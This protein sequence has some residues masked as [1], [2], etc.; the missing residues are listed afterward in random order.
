MTFAS[1][2]D[3]SH[4][5]DALVT[6]GCGVSPPDISHK[7]PAA[8]PVHCEPVSRELNSFGITTSNWETI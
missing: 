7:L 6:F 1:E 4:V 8:V 2:S 3:K 5:S